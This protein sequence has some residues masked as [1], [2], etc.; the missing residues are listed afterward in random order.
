TVLD[1]G[2]PLSSDV[3]LYAQ[4]MKDHPG[5]VTLL[6]LNLG[7]TEDQTL[8]LPE[9]SMRYTLTA[10]E[11]MSKSVELNGKKL[12]LAANGDVPA[13]AGVGAAKG[14]VALPAASITFLAIG[15]AKNA[16]CR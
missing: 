9:R 2:T 14:T 16:A 6:A 3:R 4:C 13:L 10:T 12:E 11:L 7:R 15:D 8:E 5:G 1:A